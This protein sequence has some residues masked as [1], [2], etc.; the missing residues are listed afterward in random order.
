MVQEGNQCRLIISE[1]P[2]GN[3]EPTPII[4]PNKAI[5]P[6][7][8]ASG[9]GGLAWTFGGVGGAHDTDRAF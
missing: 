4:S 8:P 7:V 2:K 3:D 6:T 9:A 1:T 5:K